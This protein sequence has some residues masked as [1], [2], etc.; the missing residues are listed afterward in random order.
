[1]KVMRDEGVGRLS[2]TGEVVITPI[3]QGLWTMIKFGFYSKGNR[4]MLKGFK[5]TNIKH[6]LKPYSRYLVG[7]GLEKQE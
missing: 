6:I 3:I 1:M 7:T 2:A 4:M 5:L